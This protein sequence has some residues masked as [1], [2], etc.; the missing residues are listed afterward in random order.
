MDQAE[1]IAEMERRAKELGTAMYLVCEKAG[2]APTTFYRWKSG[3]D[4]NLA[5][6]RKLNDALD[7]MEKARA[8]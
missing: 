3:S 8:A 5:T 2:V 7:G 4:A 1:I 6:I